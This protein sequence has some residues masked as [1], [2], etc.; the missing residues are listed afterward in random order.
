L[1]VAEYVPPT[2]GLIGLTAQSSISGER[3]SSYSGVVGQAAAS[4]TLEYGDRDKSSFRLV[5]T[6]ALHKEPGR[7][8]SELAFSAIHL[9]I[10]ALGPA[11]RP[12]ADRTV[13]SAQQR[14]EELAANQTLW[15]N[16]NW[17]LEKQRLPAKVCRYGDSWAGYA[18][19]D[20]RRGVIVV[21]IK[22]GVETIHLQEIEDDSTLVP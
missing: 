11:R 2:F 21:G 6:E 17:L 9:L 15:E 5:R 14:T 19:V 18:I 1:V 22:V 13:V 20:A 16:Q 8:A 12:A 7:V 4:V 3:F 10:N